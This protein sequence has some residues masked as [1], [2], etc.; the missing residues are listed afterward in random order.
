[1]AVAAAQEGTSEITG[2]AQPSAMPDEPEVGQN[3]V[4][5]D[6][7][8]AT[9]ARQPFSVDP[10]LVDRGLRGHA[11]TQNALA[12]LI[13]A[14]ARTARANDPQFD[15]AWL[16]DDVLYVA[17]VKSLTTSNEEQQLRLGLGQVLRYAH[18]LSSSGREVRPVLAVEHQPSDQSWQNL[19]ERLG[20]LLV[21]PLGFGRLG[22]L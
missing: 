11:R 4:D 15:L 13:G 20:V 7:E 8:A 3:Y 9:S 2:P 22:S 10:N 6:E 12:D 14:T 21:W 16:S 19:C 5:A 1:M 18:L 17:E